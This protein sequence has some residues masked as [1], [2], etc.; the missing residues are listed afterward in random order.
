MRIAIIIDGLAVGGA[1]K[2]AAVAAAELTWRGEDVEL[3]SYGRQNEYE[4][5]LRERGVRVSLI[6]NKGPFRLGRIRALASHLRRRRVDV[7][8]AF[9]KTSSIWGRAAAKV[10][11]VS[12]IFGGYRGL[13]AEPPV[14]RWLLKGLSRNTAGWIVNSV[15]VKRFLIREF[16]VEPES[17][18][19]AH[20]GIDVAACRSDLSKDQARACFGVKNGTP[21]VCAVGNLR[22]VK[23]HVMLLR[24]AKRLAEADVEATFL[25]AGD[26]SCREQLEAMSEELGISSSVRF[27]GQC[28]RIPDL[29]R[30]TDIAVMTSI[31]EGLPN[32][33]IEAGAAALPCVVTD[34]GAADEVVIDG[35]TGYIVPAND[36][37]EMAKKIRMLIDSPQARTSMGLAALEHIEQKFST[38]ALGARLLDIYAQGLLKHAK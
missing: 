17:V 7:V 10:A 13:T 26:G 38:D 35:K 27:L 33:V 29:L 28:D 16:S 25:L 24:V 32:A 2:Q 11:G 12:C 18:A 19:I 5:F 14:S 21:V 22:P 6:T 34:Y 36:D 1:E 30:A 15:G 20:N 37:A 23:N 8:H 4:D 9:K 3:I 31:T